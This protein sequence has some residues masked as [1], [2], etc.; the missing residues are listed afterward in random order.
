MD[1]LIDFVGTSQAIIKEI[2]VAVH[3]VDSDGIHVLI[4][5]IKKAD[6]IFCV[7]AGRSRLILSAFCM[8]LNHLGF[9]SYVAGNIPCPP[10]GNGDLIIR[11]TG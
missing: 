4:D 5:S 11:A 1:E 10:A 2:E 6:K 7:G 9:S 8:R 3:S